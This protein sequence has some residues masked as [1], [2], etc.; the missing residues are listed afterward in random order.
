MRHETTRELFRYWNGVRKE[1]A[2]PERD[3]IDPAAIRDILADTFILERKAD[4]TFPVRVSGTR[5]DALWLEDQK[6]RSFL[7]FWADDRETLAAALST[8]MDS[9]TPIVIGAEVAP[10][11]R[12]AVPAE[13]LLLPMRHHGRTHSLILGA[14]SLAKPPSWIGLVP[15]ERLKLVSF[16]MVAPIEVERPRRHHWD[17]M[18]VG[19]ILERRA[20]LTVY[21][22]GR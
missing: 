19:G 2:T 1:R 17:E 3:E 5:L 21:A 9:A 18:P 15:V 6:G 8:V 20:H 22:G 16:R 7:D 4:G 10:S 11:G 13:G 14:F 12:P